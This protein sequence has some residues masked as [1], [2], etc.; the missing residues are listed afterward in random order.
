MFEDTRKFLK[1][2]KLPSS[3]DLTLK[4][5]NKKFKDDADFRIEVPTINSFS[6]AKDLLSMAEQ[7]NIIINRI[8]E[9]YGLFRHTKG[10]I[11]NWV[12]LARDYGC[13]LMMSHGPRATYDTSA[14]ARSSQGQRIG[15]RLRGQ[16]Q[17]VRAIEDILRG[18]EYGVRNF[19]IYDEGLLTVVNEMR[20]TSKIPKEVKFKISAHCGCANP[21]SAKMFENLGA[22]SINPVRDLQSPMLASIRQAISI[23]MDCHTDNPKASGGFIRTYEIPEIIKITAPVYLK[24]GNSALNEHG[25]VV[26]KSQ[27]EQM[28]TQINVVLEMINRYHPEATQSKNKPY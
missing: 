17:I 6:A 8:T 28:V 19:L 18:I 26:S 22:D 2:A 3:D 14:T 16:E 24:S 23:P 15:Y 5:S 13:E 7:S 12:A 9:T 10:E 1:Y 20:K 21:A 27:I 4:Q 25:A 11:L